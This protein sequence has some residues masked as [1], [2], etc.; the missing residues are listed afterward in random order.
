MVGT[1]KKGHNAF[2][3][4]DLIKIWR[5][6]KSSQNQVETY[7]LFLKWCELVYLFL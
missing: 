5:I 4:Y 1:N 2:I 3:R 6:F 7:W